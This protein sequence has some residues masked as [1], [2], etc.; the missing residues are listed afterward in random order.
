MYTT[1]FP[2]LS[3]SIYRAHREA[4][5]PVVQSLHNYR[6]GCASGSYQR[7]GKDC[8]LCTPGNSQPAIRHR[9]Y[10]NSLI[11]SYTWKRVM[12]HNWQNGTFT[13]AVDHYICP[14]REVMQQHLQMGLPAERMTVITNACP[15]AG[16]RKPARHTTALE[17]LFIGRLVEEKGCATL[18]QAWLKLDPAIRRKATLKIVGQGP[19]LEKLQVQTRTEADI[20]FTGALPSAAVIS[21]LQQASLLVCPSQWAEPF[22]LTL[23]EAMSA[24]VPVIASNVGS[25]P[26]IVRNGQNGWLVPPAMRQGCPLKSLRYLPSRSY[27]KPSAGRVAQ[28]MS[29]TTAHPNMHVN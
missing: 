2:L 18:I 10:R 11:G 14:S 20:Q 26:E 1:G 4:G 12:D 19:E 5:I 29:N 24:S 27:S 23:I 22:G 9:C 6:L 3:P 21:L 8:S 7:A 25:I 16:R 13:K 15:D 17:V 28:R